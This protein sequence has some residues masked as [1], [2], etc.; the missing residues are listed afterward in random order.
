MV[1]CMQIVCSTGTIGVMVGMTG[2]SATL[3]VVRVTFSDLTAITL[4][5]IF[6]LAAPAYPA[7]FVDDELLADG[8]LLTNK[9][10]PIA[11]WSDAGA[12]EPNAVT[13]SCPTQFA[14]T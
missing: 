9:E 5:L 1:C 12:V 11:D 13:E 4:G 6:E 14:L 3:T 10:A 7:L 2:G 8:L